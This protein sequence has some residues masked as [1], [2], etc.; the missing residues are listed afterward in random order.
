MAAI[1]C[2]TNHKNCLSERYQ[3]SP[4]RIEINE[5]FVCVAADRGRGKNR[6]KK[7]LLIVLELFMIPTVSPVSHNQALGRRGITLGK[8]SFQ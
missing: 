7:N 2:Y 5:Y 6:M 8:Y 1:F 3:P 4:K